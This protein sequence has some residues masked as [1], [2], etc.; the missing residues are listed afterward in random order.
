MIDALYVLKDN[1]TDANKELPFS[2]RS[3]E[4]HIRGIRNLVIVSSTIPPFLNP[5]M[6]VHV[7]ETDRETTKDQSIFRKVLTACNDSRVSDSFLFLN[8]DHFILQDVEASAVP[9]FYK[10]GDCRITRAKG[11]G[12][13]SRRLQLTGRALHAAGFRDRHYDV[14]FPIVYRKTAFQEIAEF[15]PWR[16]GMGFTVKSL[17]GNYHRLGGPEV[18]DC[19]IRHPVSN[20]KF[21]RI[22]AGRF[23]FSTDEKAMDAAM[24][25]RLTAMYGTG[26]KWEQPQE[27]MA[28]QP[29]EIIRSR[30]PVTLDT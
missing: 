1:T 6:V 2:L 7:E 21:N 30:K 23:C 20:E 12:S 8:D 18:S 29:A 25:A 13:Y 27:P 19:K 14:H 9:Y 10:G 24:V 16:R 22:T 11:Y 28:E 17:Y 26:S 4:K 5:E 3:I 15:F